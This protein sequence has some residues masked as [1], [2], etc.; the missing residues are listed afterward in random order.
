METRPAF[1][2]LTD[3]ASKEPVV[4]RA[5]EVLAIWTAIEQDEELGQYPTGSNIFTLSGHGIGEPPRIPVIETVQ[6]VVRALNHAGC[7]LGSPDGG[8]M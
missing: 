8:V 1:I 6:E 4:L 5:D 3:R 2:I 7:P